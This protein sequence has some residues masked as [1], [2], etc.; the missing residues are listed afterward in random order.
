LRAHPLRS[1]A[2]FRSSSGSGIHLTSLGALLLLLLNWLLPT[3]LP[4]YVMLPCG[5]LV[6]LIE[7]GNLV[8][9]LMNGSLNADSGERLP[10]AF[11]V[12]LL[13]SAPITWLVL[14]LHGSL[15]HYLLMWLGVLAVVAA[16]R[17]MVPGRLPGVVIDD[18]RTDDPLWQPRSLRLALI[19][20]LIIGTYAAVRWGPRDTDSLLYLAHIQERLISPVLQPRDPLLGLES[21]TVSP[22]LWLNPWLMAQG[23]LVLLTRADPVAVVFDEL[24]PL[25][26][27][28]SLAAWYGLAYTLFRRRSL[29][30]FAVLVQLF[31]F[32]A[33]FYSHDG[34]GNAFFARAAEDKMLLWLVILPVAVRWALRWLAD[35]RQMD[36]LGYALAGIIAI[37]L[38]P[39][40]VV[41][42]ALFAGSMLI[43]R[44][45][46]NHN[47]D[48]V[49]R[50]AWLLLIPLLLLPYVWFE[51]V[52]EP[53]IPYVV[54]RGSPLVDFRLILAA[55]RLLFL[56]SGW[57]MVHPAMVAYPAAPASPPSSQPGRSIPAG[58]NV[59][60]PFR[61]IQPPHRHVAGAVHHSLAPLAR[62]LGD[63]VR[64]P[65]GGRAVSPLVPAVEAT[66][67]PPL[68]ATAVGR[69]ARR[70]LVSG[71]PATLI[72]CLERG[73]LLAT[74]RRSYLR[75]QCC[76]T[77][78]TG[79][80]HPRAAPN[81]PHHPCPPSQRA[82]VGVSRHT[83]TAGA[84][85]GCGCLL[86]ARAVRSSGMGSGG[87]IRRGV[88]GRPLPVR[89]G[90]FP[91]QSSH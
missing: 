43:T 34:P 60:P 28:L 80:P 88:C 7:P 76:A 84:A 18:V 57:V 8:L 30:F 49:L 72:Q 3:P 70:P 56:P 10:L 86:S 12:G 55:H 65:A 1:A 32:T 67:P 77:H 87:E 46:F 31:L 59:R 4:S 66:V 14:L 36:A 6:M 47:R 89:T 2:L 52:N 19:A 39:I 21:L 63:P 29:A 78:Q 22:R 15:H 62:H 85:T 20:L 91:G 50:L 83:A 26:A 9:D 53:F 23:G 68:A 37:L 35:G 75:P 48:D 45:P 40:G 61:P 74:T 58:D 38:H 24:P 71:Q 11:T 90:R 25:L 82:C 44:L 54:E 41:L 16:S 81:Q 13:L 51:Q 79:A 42:V 27:L 73:E 33:T 64:P 5:L 69:P 17:F